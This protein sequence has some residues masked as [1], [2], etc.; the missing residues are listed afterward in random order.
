MTRFSGPASSSPA[1][2]RCRSRGYRTSPAPTAFA[3]CRY[4]AQWR[5]DFDPAGKRVAVIGTD[6]T[7]GHYIPQL[8]DSAASVTVFAHPP[9]RIVPELP[10]P[11][12][13]AK[14]WLRRQIGPAVGNRRA[15]TLVGSAI[16]TINPSGIRTTDGSDYMD[17]DADAIIYGTGFAIPD[18]TSDTTLVGAG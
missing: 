8:I 15:P 1:T 16:S 9:R 12:T 4:A 14:R 17:H 2:G 7:A 3:E 5:P 18:R 10:L 6:A 13:R 11:T